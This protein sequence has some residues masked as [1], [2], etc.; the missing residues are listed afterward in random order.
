MTTVAQI[1]ALLRK[2]PYVNAL[3]LY[4]SQAD[5]TAQANSDVDLAVQFADFID[6]SEQRTLRPHV[7]KVE[8]CSALNCRE[9]QLS[10]VD[11]AIAPPALAWEILSTGQLLFC[12]DDSKRIRLECKIFSQYELDIEYHRKRYG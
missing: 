9:D 5:G 11:L 2:L 10:I 6:N 7:L 12:Y 1:E 8:L 3:W 4:G